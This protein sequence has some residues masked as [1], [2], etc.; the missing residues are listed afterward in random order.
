MHEDDFADEYL[1][2]AI[3]YDEMTDMWSFYVGEHVG[4]A[5]TKEELVKKMWDLI[6]NWKQ[7]VSE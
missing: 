1:P 2:I 5:D 3:T 6:N 7:D 4:V